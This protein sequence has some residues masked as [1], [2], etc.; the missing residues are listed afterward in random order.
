MLWLFLTRRTAA[1]L[2]DLYQKVLPTYVNH[3]FRVSQARKL[4]VYDSTG[5][6]DNW[7]GIKIFG[8]RNIMSR[9]GG[10]GG[11]QVVSVLAFYADD[12]CPNKK[13]PKYKSPR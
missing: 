10:Q 9:G 6:I 8:N 1:N 5:V 12:Q 4:P 2:T 11:G 13:N 3:N 7:R